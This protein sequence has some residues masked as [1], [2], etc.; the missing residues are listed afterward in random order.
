MLTHLKSA[1]RHVTNSFLKKYAKTLQIAQSIL[2][3]VK[4]DTMVGG[5]TLTGM[6][7]TSAWYA[8]GAGTAQVRRPQGLPHCAAPRPAAPALD[9]ALQKKDRPPR[10]PL[11]PDSRTRPH[12]SAAAHPRT[13]A[14][15]K[16]LRFRYKSPARGTHAREHRCARH[17][18]R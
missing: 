9:A 8:P 6:L 5:A 16:S 15:S 2:A 14:L 13:R 18:A 12:A 1:S 4:A 11:M 10:R 3:K 17:G 7:G